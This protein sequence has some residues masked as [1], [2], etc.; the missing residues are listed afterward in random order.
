[1]E[2]ETDSMSLNGNVTSIK[3]LFRGYLIEEIG[4]YLTKAKTKDAK[5]PLAIWIM[6]SV[7]AYLEQKTQEDTK[8]VTVRPRIGRGVKLFLLCLPN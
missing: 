1:M 2:A 5:N 7:A 4:C 8:T 6:R 3:D